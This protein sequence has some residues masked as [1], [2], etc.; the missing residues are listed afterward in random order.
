MTAKASFNSSFLQP[1]YWSTWCLLGINRLCVYLPR[2]WALGVGGVLGV[3]F[4][5]LNAKRRRITRI[6]IEMCFPELNETQRESLVREHFRC[7]GQSVV[8][9]GLIWWASEKKLDQLTDIKGLE[10]FRN[11]VEAD[12]NIILLTPHAIGM[13]FGG[14]AVS[15]LHPTVSMMKPLKNELLNY[16]VLRGRERYPSTRIVMRDDGLRPMI[17]GIRNHQ[18][19]YYIPDEDF[20][21]ESSVFVPFFGIPTATLPTLGRMTQITNAAVVPCFTCLTDNGRYEVTLKP[22]LEN[23][24]SGDIEQDAQRMNMELEQGLR[25]MPAQYM[26][27]LRWFKTTVDG[28]ESPYA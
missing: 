6:N 17:R 20:G 9:F 25:A 28:S 8:D 24:P 4:L 22:A 26:W 15:R 27:T 5:K 1:R 18:A 13:D 19:C 3:L 7:Y 2:R 16:F 23:Y 10:E 11:L 21:A 14:V 12:R